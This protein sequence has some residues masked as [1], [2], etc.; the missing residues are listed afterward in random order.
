[1]TR[2]FTSRPP[3]AA[4]EPRLR[5]WTHLGTAIGFTAAGA[6]DRIRILSAATASKLPTETVSG[7]LHDAPSAVRHRVYRSLRRHQHQHHPPADE[8]IEP[9][10]R[11]W[12]DRE[13]ARLLPGCAPHVITALL[14]ELAHA[15]TTWRPL[16]TRHPGIHVN[17]L[18][19]QLAGLPVIQHDDCWR[20]HEDALATVAPLFPH[21]LLAL[22]E[23]FAPAH[24]LPP[25][26]QHSRALAH[27]DPGRYIRLLIDTG[28][29]PWLRRTT[30][31]RGVI[32]VLAAAEPPELVEL[33][34]RG[35][36][37]SVLEAL[38]PSRREA[39]YDAVHPNGPRLIPDNDMNLPLLPAPRRHREARQ[40]IETSRR[41]GFDDIVLSTVSHLP[42][43]EARTELGP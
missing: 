17:E 26:V 5:G 21:R 10:R 13:A 32:K 7:L 42:L 35:K 38:P 4:V 27:A 20:R 14:P 34:K 9:V 36:L 43:D 37:P 12:G 39:L 8:M 19:R 15:V 11:W 22:L 41:S 2:T 30:P 24:R 18:E 40:R 25:F 6:T 1:M 28:R 16:A 33:A 29:V 31:G 3:H 23:R